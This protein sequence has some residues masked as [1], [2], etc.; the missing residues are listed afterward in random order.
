MEYF[1]SSDHLPIERCSLPLNRLSRLSRQLSEGELMQQGNDGKSGSPNNGEGEGHLLMNIG[2][3]VLLV[4]VL[5]AAWFFLEWL[6]G[7][8]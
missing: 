4:S 7:G 1:L 5:V 6:M 2:K 8:R 3:I